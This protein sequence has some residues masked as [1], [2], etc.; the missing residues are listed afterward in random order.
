MKKKKLLL[1]IA[2]GLLAAMVLGLEAYGVDAALH[3]YAGQDPRD[4]REV[5]ARNK[6]FFTAMFQPQP[7]YLGATIPISGDGDATNDQGKDTVMAPSA[8]QRM[9][10]A[11]AVPNIL[12]LSL[13]SRDVKE[14]GGISP[15]CTILRQLFH[16]PSHLASGAG[17]E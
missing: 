17:M 14:G 11:F 6:D 9:G 7:T 15:L 8:K 4:I 12:R 2:L 5:L 3:H 10:T 16:A 1:L 13:F